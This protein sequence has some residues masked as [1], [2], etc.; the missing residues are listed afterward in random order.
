[1]AGKRERSASPATPMKRRA[2][3][4]PQPRAAAVAASKALLS[5]STPSV[6]DDSSRANGKDSK[7]SADGSDRRCSEDAAEKSTGTP[8]KRERRHFSIMTA[9]SPVLA[10]THAYTCR[11]I[12]KSA[13]REEGSSASKRSVDYDS[14]QDDISARGVPLSSAAE[15]GAASKTATNAESNHSGAD[16]ANYRNDYDNDDDGDDDIGDNTA[17]LDVNPNIGH[18]NNIDYTSDDNGDDGANLSFFLPADPL[19]DGVY[20]P[21]PTSLPSPPTASDALL[22]SSPTLASP[23]TPIEQGLL[24]LCGKHDFASHNDAAAAWDALCTTM[25]RVFKRHRRADSPTFEDHIRGAVIVEAR[26]RR[27]SADTSAGGAVPSPPLLHTS[28]PRITDPDALAVPAAA[29][30]GQQC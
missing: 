30:S 23:R 2:A 20:T 17:A 27:A 16:D 5:Q 21:E 18:N 1:M 22:A 14:S 24:W 28:P 8:V 9:A 6:S 15:R 29:V 11:V 7:D 3:R 12:I 26:S 13:R 25:P 10:A 4:I 19:E